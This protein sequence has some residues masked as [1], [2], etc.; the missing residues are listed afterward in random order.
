MQIERLVDWA[1]EFAHIANHYRDEVEALKAAAPV[2]SIEQ[3]D[4][5]YRAREA[6]SQA[7]IDRLLKELDNVVDLISRRNNTP[8]STYTERGSQ[9]SAKVTVP[10]FYNDESKDTVKFEVWYR[11]MKNRITD[12]AD[13]FLNDRAIR[14]DI[15]SHLGGTA[16]EHLQPY[17][18][19]NHPNQL[20]T[21]EQLLAHLWDVYHD[22]NADDKAKTEWRKL[23][24]EK[25]YTLATFPA[26]KAE[27]VRLAGE[28]CLEKSK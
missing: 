10:V 26:F 18:S 6:Q 27:F 28:Y 5:G 24:M 25:Q 3:P 21:S 9:K 22:V 19:D 16:A 4:P 20:K 23:D 14:T 11:N 12:N 7:T 2:T 17:L 1:K 8:S 15:K 13:W